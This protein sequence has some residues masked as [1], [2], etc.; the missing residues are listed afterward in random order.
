MFP[1]LPASV[2]QSA[3]NFEKFSAIHM[4]S[5][6][7]PFISIVHV[8]HL[9]DSL[10]V[11]SFFYVSSLHFVWKFPVGVFSADSLLLPPSV[12]GFLHFCDCRFDFQHFLS[13]Y[14]T[15]LL[16]RVVHFVH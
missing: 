4:S 12:S 1:E 9:C 3:V 7:S 6:L 8:Y 14:I 15:H 16:L 5:L 10:L 11:F 2:V 13:T